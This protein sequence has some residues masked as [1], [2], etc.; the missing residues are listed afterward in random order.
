MNGNNLSIGRNH[1]TADSVSI[2]DF[3]DCFRVDIRWMDGAYVYSIYD[4]KEEALLHV[5]KLG[6]A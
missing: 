6:W 4:T 2:T 5:H 3:V 1:S